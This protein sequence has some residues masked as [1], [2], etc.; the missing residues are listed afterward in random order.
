M[1]RPRPLKYGDMLIVQG[2]NDCELQWN[3][4]PKPGGIGVPE[5]TFFEYEE[6]ADY[7]SVFI[8]LDNN[9]QA[10]EIAAFVGE[11][12]VGASVVA[13]NDSIVEI[14]AY[15]Q[16][17]EGNEM[18]FITHSS[19]KSVNTGP[20]DYYVKDF[21][22]LQYVKRKI[23]PY[24]KKPF[25]L[26]SFKDKATETKAEL[27]VY[28]FPNPAKEELNIHFNLP[29][30]DI[31]SLEILDINGKTLDR[32]NLGHYPKGVHQ[33]HYQIPEYFSSGVYFYKFVTGKT[34]VVNQL[35][36]Q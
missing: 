18:N 12:C 9:T 3:T 23:R 15:L 14:R 2:I 7:T 33:Y 16:G 10:D 4:K 25:H 32:V 28:H 8:E 5:T 26:V 34:T 35:I 19:N 21:S 13:E 1:S 11:T 22:S 24:D 29:K 30:D 36:I 31:V 27:L 6:Q 20:Q 17:V